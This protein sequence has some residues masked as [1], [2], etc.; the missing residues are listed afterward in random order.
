MMA[1]NQAKQL[2]LIVEDSGATRETL[3]AFLRQAGYVVLGAANGQEALDCL[4]REPPPDLIVLDM[5]MPIMD[6][7]RFLKELAQLNPPPSAPIIIT[8]SGVTTREWAL[9]HGA[10]GF[11][12]KPIDPG[13]LL[14][15]IERCIGPA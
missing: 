6:G 9:A 15:E 1:T 8:T 7:W 11:V 5:M 2:L 13:E 14:R 3:G 12:H 10:A 4:E